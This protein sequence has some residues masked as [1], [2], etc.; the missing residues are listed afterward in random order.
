MSAQ[1]RV[2]VVIPAL[3]EEASIGLVLDALPQDRIEEVL[4]VDNGSTDGTAA[5]ARAHGATVVPEPERGYGA[6]CLR[7]IAAAGECDVL[8]FVDA[9]FSDHPEELALLL[10]PIER[11][12]ADLVIGTRMVRPES[13]R[14]L[15][16]QARFGNRLAAYLLRVLYGGR[17]T[18]LGPFRV[19]RR[20]ALARLAMDDRDFGWTVQMQARAFRAGL[21]VVE[22][23][24]S[25]RQRV[26][27]SKI[28]GTVS[29][30][31]RAGVKILW[32]VAR[33]R[34][35]RRRFPG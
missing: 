3:D 32:T 10:A 24:V 31:I 9:D 1:L 6:A 20:D 23:P 18:D 14:A 15:L 27:V 19:V 22:V 28:T 33:E 26:G 34:L 35:R 5:A 29:G 17:A 12:E 13:R 30:T 25:Y 7:G 16:P 8:A 2:K 11:D 21:R 4:V